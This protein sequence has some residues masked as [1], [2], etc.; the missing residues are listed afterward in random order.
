MKCLGTHSSEG[1]KDSYQFLFDND[2]YE[3]CRDTYREI[4]D[5]LRNIADNSECGE[6]RCTANANIVV[7]CDV[8]MA[9]IKERTASHKY[10]NPYTYLAISTSLLVISVVLFILS[11]SL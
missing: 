10:D 4:C 11:I 6:C 7:L 3:G 1:V 2:T 5:E 9:K 8:W